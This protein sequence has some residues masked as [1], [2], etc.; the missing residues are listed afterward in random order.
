VDGGENPEALL[1]DERDET[2]IAFGRQLA[3]D[4]NRISDELFARLRGYLTE[5]QVVELTVFGALM[6]VNNVVNSA[7]RVEVDEG[8]SGYAIQPEIAFVGSSHF[9]S[10]RE[11]E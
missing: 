6:I 7:L 8:L 2:I 1:L 4:P 9:Q 3:A 5:A 10:D 11:V